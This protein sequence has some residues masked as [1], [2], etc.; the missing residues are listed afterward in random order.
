MVIVTKCN[1]KAEKTKKEFLNLSYFQVKLCQ[2]TGKQYLIKVLSFLF[3]SC[4]QLLT[5]VRFVIIYCFVFKNALHLT[6]SISNFCHASIVHIL[7]LRLNENERERERKTWNLK[8]DLNWKQFNLLAIF[9][10]H[11]KYISSIKVTVVLRKSTEL[12]WQVLPFLSFKGKKNHY[13]T[14]GFPWKW[15]FR[16]VH[17]FSCHIVC[18]WFVSWFEVV[19]GHQISQS[20]LGCGGKRRFLCVCIN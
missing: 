11:E 15:N 7:T 8:S 12:F 4:R 13:G 18:S 10:K 5:N 2:I 16:L 19:H 6:S 9:M 3:D 1:T 14:T 20:H 17:V